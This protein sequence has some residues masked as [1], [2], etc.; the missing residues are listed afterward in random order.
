MKNL[1][2]YSIFLL[3]LTL[4]FSCVKEG[5]I[6]TDEE[7]EVIQQEG[8]TRLLTGMVRDTTGSTIPQAG[9]KIVFD[10]PDKD[11]DLELVTEAD[12]NGLWE[13]TVPKS[14]T[15][16]YVIGNKVAYSKSIQRLKI[17]E[18]ERTE[19]LYLVDETSNT[20]SD[21]SLRLGNLKTV[22]GRLIDEN[23]NSISDVNIFVFS[24][25]NGSDETVFN[26]Y[27]FTR[28]DG[29]FEIIYEAGDFN[30]TTLI[31]LISNGCR[32]AYSKS[33]TGEDPIEDLGEVEISYEGFTIFQSSTVRDDFSCYDNESMMAYYW[34]LQTAFQPVIYDQPLGD[35]ELEYCPKDNGA[36]YIGVENEGNAHFNGVFVTAEE[37]LE[38]YKFDIC[39]PNPGNFV[40]L[41]INGKGVLFEDNLSLI[42]PGK[43]AYQDS[44]LQL[45][46]EVLTWAIFTPLGSEKPAYQIGELRSFAYIG[47]IEIG[48]HSLEN[49][50]PKFNYVNIVQDDENYFAGIAQIKLQSTDGSPADIAIRFRVSK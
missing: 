11:I 30:A 32:D 49:E 47:D 43:I 39:T 1:T 37:A 36:F 20:D 27:D 23:G 12:K 24:S 10:E 6:I 28:E 34:D 26:G 38:A 18:D 31:A 4:C 33:L 40:E 19:D 48:F 35:F 9:V 45:L 25:L 13:L 14:L 29:S 15:E 41:L 17:T 21:L 46:F 50:S 16:G 8:E 44:E 3:I 2:N 22:M 5:D 42:G 7:T